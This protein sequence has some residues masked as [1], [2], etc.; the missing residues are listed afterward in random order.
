V[1]VRAREDPDAPLVERFLRDENSLRVA[2]L[3]RLE[4]PLDHPALVAE[5]E[6]G[7]LVGVLTYVGGE[8]EGEILT[9]HAT[10]QWA[11]A[12]TALVEALKRHAP[13]AAGGASGS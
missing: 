3:G 13:S 9:L 5:D 8:G 11:G 12:G 1:R 7:K 10:R 2:R 6:V 4:R